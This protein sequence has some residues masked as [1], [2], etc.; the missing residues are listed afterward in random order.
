MERK[1][2]ASPTFVWLETGGRDGDGGN[3]Q[4][5][6]AADRQTDVEIAAAHQLAA[7]RERA[8]IRGKLIQSTIDACLSLLTPFAS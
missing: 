2:K 7:E 3:T 4:P 8:W 5:R 6:P 1:K